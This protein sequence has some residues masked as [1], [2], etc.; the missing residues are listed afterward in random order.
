MATEIQRVEHRDGRTVALTIAYRGRQIEAD[1][2]IE[3]SSLKIRI[4]ADGTSFGI[5]LGNIS[6]EEYANPQLHR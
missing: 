4:P 3:G 2:V 5:A 6:D 1:V